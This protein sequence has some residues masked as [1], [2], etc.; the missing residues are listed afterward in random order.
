[1]A[2]SSL[3]LIAI[4]VSCFMLIAGFSICYD[5]VD[6]F[7]DRGYEVGESPIQADIEYSGWQSLGSSEATLADGIITFPLDGSILNTSSFEANWT[8]ATISFEVDHYELHVDSSS[9]WL[10]GNETSFLLPP[11]SEGEHTLWLRAF[12]ET[13]EYEEDSLT[14][15]TDTHSPQL[16][17]LSP[18]EG[19][20]FNQTT[21]TIS[22]SADDSGT[23]I[24][25]FEMSVDGG[26]WASI[27]LVTEFV[28]PPLADGD[29]VIRLK[30]M[31]MANNTAMDDVSFIVDIDDPIVRFINPSDGDQ[32]NTSSFTME[33]E[34]FASSS[35]V[36]RYELRVDTRS[37]MI[38]GGIET[39][40]LPMLAEGMHEAEI[41][42]Y[43]NAGNTASDIL[44]F[45]ID[46]VLPTLSIQCPEEMQMFN[47]SG[48]Y[49]QWQGDDDNSGIDHY[50]IGID[51][52]IWVSVEM[53][54]TFALPKLADGNHSLAIK[55]IDRAGN[56]YTESKM[57]IIDTLDPVVE[58]V[59]P[60]DATNWNKTF[61]EV[62]W[63][64]SDTGSGIDY[65]EVQLD[66]SNW[67]TVGMNNSHPLTLLSEGEHLFSVRVW[68]RIGNSA[69]DSVNF[70]VTTTIPVLEIL[71]PEEDSIFNNTTV[72]VEWSA[73][74]PGTGISYIEVRLD[75]GNWTNV[76]ENM[77]H[78]FSDLE[79]G[80]HT[81]TVV[82]HNNAGRFTSGSVDFLVDSISPE[83]I[84]ENPVDG[85]MLTNNS[86][87]VEFTVT[88]P[89]ED[90]SG[91]SHC[92]IRIDNSSWMEA[93]IGT[94]Y[95]LPRLADG[96]HT[97][98]LWAF[99]I[100][101]NS[102]GSNSTFLIDTL[103]PSIEIISPVN[104]SMSRSS[105]IEFRWLGNDS[106]SGINQYEMYVDE[107]LKASLESN[108]SAFVEMGE[109]L[110]EI[111]IIAY[112]LAGNSAIDTIVIRVDTVPPTLRIV[113]PMS[114]TLITNTSTMVIWSC[115][116]QNSCL[117]H[118]E[119]MIN[120][121]D[122]IYIGMNPT[123][124]LEGL[125][126]GNL[127]IAV[128]AVDNAGNEAYDFVDAT[129]AQLD[130]EQ[131]FDLFGEYWWI[132]TIIGGV[133]GLSIVFLIRRGRSG[134]KK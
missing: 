124:V 130:D 40:V 83:L 4:A 18:Q 82:V 39:F 36:D 53:N 54:Q 115:D 127:S 20:C 131:G 6:R 14:F 84:I 90:C 32:I 62:I 117:N 29:H 120:E 75:Q 46:T 86:I 99:D 57:F 119:I 16:S 33:W 79:E 35:D 23:G 114:G 67:T 44:E 28:L 65:Y 25:H 11:L 100:A 3:I 118:F 88:D 27:G 43:D 116:D 107:S 85:S 93:M 112:D 123:Y 17:I 106:G 69:N 133:V 72:S 91:V 109:G 49:A 7:S 71:S 8:N 78:T 95:E 125:E 121:N 129:V 111:S 103:P 76:G 37:W 5:G 94:P 113:T 92:L 58:I 41:T 38:L 21:V 47:T 68:D 126:P 132:L 59:Y 12:N 26:P 70:T 51:D 104:G 19:Q 45:N 13:G 97:I 55:V 89:G 50:E 61:I 110:Y 98:W 122:W 56:S 2:S 101:G 15:T 102:A 96:N 60:T 24:D 105:E 31:D 22:W 128:K 42:L 80:T 9:W 108:G 66:S 1:M 77:S 63:N 30:A 52:C 87:F 74:D 10:L 81:V 73:S 134:P 34:G 64:G 48:I